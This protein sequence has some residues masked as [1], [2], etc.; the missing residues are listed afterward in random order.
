MQEEAAAAAAV[1]TEDEE[2]EGA[3]GN[4]QRNYDYLLGMTMW[5]LTMEKKN[6]LLKNRD[7]K[8]AELEVLRKKTP[9]DLWI[10]DLNALLEKVSNSY[11]SCILVLTSEP[12]SSLF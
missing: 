6:Q 5:S 9:S 2:A 12:K 4:E 10:E 11:N 3:P 1:D 7:E 8:C